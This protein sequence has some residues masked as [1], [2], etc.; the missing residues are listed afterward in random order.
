MSAERYYEGKHFT[1]SPDKESSSSVPTKLQKES[2]SSF[3]STFDIAGIC[4]EEFEKVHGGGQKPTR[5]MIQSV[6]KH[7]YDKS[8]QYMVGDTST[9]EDLMREEV[10]RIF[11]MTKKKTQ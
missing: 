11:R 4:K 2:A 8:F 5:E 10:G 9:I 7:L 3:E 6:K 1:A